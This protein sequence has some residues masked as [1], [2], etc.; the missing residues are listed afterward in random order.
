MSEGLPT[1]Y[2]LENLGSHVEC[3]SRQAVMTVIEANW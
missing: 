1:T 3:H 2:D